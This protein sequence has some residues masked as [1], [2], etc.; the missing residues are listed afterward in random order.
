[1]Y[2][3]LDSRSVLDRDRVF[4]FDRDKVVRSGGR[5]TPGASDSTTLAGVS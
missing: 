2:F 1:M 3:R 5:L 4:V